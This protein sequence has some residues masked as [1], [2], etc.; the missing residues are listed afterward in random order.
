MNTVNFLTSHFLPENTAC[1]N[2]VLSI[3]KELEKKY[4]VNI[5][6]LTEKGHIQKTEVTQFSENITVYYVNQSNF[7]GKSFFRRAVNEIFFIFRLLQISN[8]LPHHLVIATEPYMF[9][10]PLVGLLTKG[11]KILDIRDLVWEYLDEDTIFKKIIKNILRIVM[12]FSMRKFTSII[13]TNDCEAKILSAQKHFTDIH[14]ARNGIDQSSFDKLCSI[15]PKKDIPFTVTY[16]GNIGLAQ[17]IKTLVDAAQILPDVNFIIIGNGIELPSLKKYAESLKLQNVSFTGKLPWDELKYHYENSSVLYAHL[18]QKFISA[19][20]SKLYE[21]AAVGLPI[22]Y[23][24]VGQAV[25]FIEQ[26]ENTIAI[27]PNN[28]QKL[29]DAIVTMKTSSF[30]ISEKNRLLIKENY[31]RENSA[32]YITKIV[33]NLLSSNLIKGKK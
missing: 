28:V 12:T 24:G 19:M 16:V 33:D 21:Y 31:L 30:S 23:G 14:I 29:V 9:M 17:D 22:I 18:D 5:I 3:V 20:P 27:A 13:V 15:L 7:D 25:L 32:H 11:P 26:L 6:C 2:R 1:T 4:K 8:R 10:I